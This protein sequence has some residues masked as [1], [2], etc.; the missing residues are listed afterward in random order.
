[1]LNVMRHL[2]MLPGA[3]ET[4]PLRCHLLGAGNTDDPIRVDAS[5]YFVAHVGLLEAV[6]AGQVIGEVLDFAGETLEEIRAHVDGRVVMMRGLPLIH[7]G[8]GAF[9]LTGEMPDER[10]VS[11]D[12]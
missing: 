7:A 6:R 12:G 1:V 8:E 10:R 9:L 3:P 5:G 4:R 11:S 2:A